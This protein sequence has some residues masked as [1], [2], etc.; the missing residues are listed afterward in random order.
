MFCYGSPSCSDEDLEEL[1]KCS[2]CLK[3]GLIRFV[4]MCNFLS[5]FSFAILMQ[6]CMYIKELQL[7]V[8]KN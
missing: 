2:E 3:Y 4:I 8:A 7:C 6:Q 1:L 5:L